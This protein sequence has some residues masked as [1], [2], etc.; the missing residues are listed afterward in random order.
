MVYYGNS[1]TIV[2]ATRCELMLINQPARQSGPWVMLW[3]TD[4]A[5]ILLNYC[6]TLTL[7]IRIN[8]FS[9]VLFN[10]NLVITWTM[11]TDWIVDNG[12]VMKWKNIW[13]LYWLFLNISWVCIFIFCLCLY[14]YI[15]ALIL[16]AFVC[17]FLD[18][19]MSTKGLV[20]FSTEG[21]A[22]LL[23]HSPKRT[24]VLPVLLFN[25]LTVVN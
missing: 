13:L 18:Y 24:S 15:F 20:G 1:E 5:P 23:S 10:N 17:K 6:R 25:F 9:C 8:V 19:L 7:Q 3:S 2:G 11:I 14:F 16:C 12:H 4:V 21:I 22:R